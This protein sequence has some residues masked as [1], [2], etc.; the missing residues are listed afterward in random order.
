[1]NTFFKNEMNIKIYIKNDRTCFHFFKNNINNNLFKLGLVSDL[2]PC[3]QISDL[4]IV[5]FRCKAKTEL[6]KIIIFKG[7]IN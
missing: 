2:M 7:R 3:Y 1:M 5:V 4:L 6:K